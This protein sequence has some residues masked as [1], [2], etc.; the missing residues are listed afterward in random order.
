M[1]AFAIIAYK[2]LNI[3]DGIYFWEPDAF[4]DPVWTKTWGWLTGK[5]DYSLEVAIEIK[6]RM[7]TF[8]V[9]PIV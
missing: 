8:K 9:D 1:A 7:I 6:H 4:K 5:M 3:F 2:I